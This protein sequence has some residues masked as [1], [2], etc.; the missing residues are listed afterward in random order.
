MKYTIEVMQLVPNYVQVEIEAD[1]LH[2]AIAKAK[3]YDGDDWALDWEC[4]RHVQAVSAWEGDAY[5]GPDLMAGIA[6]D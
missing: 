2:E 1:N 4:A 6:D 5:N 3:E